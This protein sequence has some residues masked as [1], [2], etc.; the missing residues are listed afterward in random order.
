MSSMPRIPD[1]Y[2]P[3]LE[4]TALAYLATLGPKGDPQVSAIWFGWDGTQLFFSMTS[5]RQKHRNLLREPRLAVAIADLTNPYRSLEIRG[6][7]RIERDAPHRFGK[8]LSRKYLQREPTADETPPGEA[9]V[10]V[11]VEPQR[12]LVFPFRAPTS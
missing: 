7:A 11:F 8:L 5:V 6:V 3:I 12:V 2:L 10:V 9:R 4:L 1:D